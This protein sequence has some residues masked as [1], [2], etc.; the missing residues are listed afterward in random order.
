MPE[1]VDQRV[2][3]VLR[4]VALRVPVVQKDV[5]PLLFVERKIKRDDAD[6]IIGRWVTVLLVN[7]SQALV[8]AYEGRCWLIPGQGL[9]QA[10]PL[11]A[12]C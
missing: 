2:E 1:L 9:N 4:E 11:Q 3:L 10:E 8:A 5:E 7:P 6:F 12:P